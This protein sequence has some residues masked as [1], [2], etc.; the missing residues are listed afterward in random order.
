MKT[1][2]EFEKV[3]KDTITRY[4]EIIFGADIPICMTCLEELWKQQSP[5]VDGWYGKEIAWD[6]L[7][8]N[9]VMDGDM[10]IGRG[11][12]EVLGPQD[13]STYWKNKF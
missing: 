9:T 4:T 1:K 3:I 8:K 13:D 6:R 10:M 7:Q 5:K 11:T 12:G 2:E